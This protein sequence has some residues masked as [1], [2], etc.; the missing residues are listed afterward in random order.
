HFF[1]ASD[2]DAAAF[3]AAYG[4]ERPYFLVVGNRRGVDGYKNVMLLFRAL[5]EWK[6]VANHELICVGGADT[7]EAELRRCAH[8]RL[9]ARRVVRSDDELGGAYA[10]AVALVYPSRYEGFGLPVVEAMAGGCP[11]ITTPVASLPEIA[12]EAALY[13]EPDDEAGLRQA[14]DEIREP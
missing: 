1:G 4:V 8:R 6:E 5:C 9:R 13:V 10:G 7:I 11:V 2:D 14:L 3:R 12:Q